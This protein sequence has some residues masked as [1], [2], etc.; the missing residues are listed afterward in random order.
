[1]AAEPPSPPPSAASFEESCSLFDDSTTSYTPFS[2][3]EKAISSTTTTDSKSAEDGSFRL[4]IKWNKR[5]KFCTIELDHQNANSNSSKLKLHQLKAIACSKLLTP[6]EIKRIKD[7]NGEVKLSLVRNVEN[8]QLVELKNDGDVQMLRANDTVEVTAGNVKS[9][10]SKGIS[11]SVVRWF[12][13]DDDGKWKAYTS[14]ISTQMETAL[15]AGK[16]A[17]TIL[18]G[19][20]CI[21]FSSREQLR[22][23]TQKTRRCLR[24][25]W[26]WTAD[27]GALVPYEEA[28]ATKLEAAYTELQSDT[29][30]SATKKVAVDTER[31]CVVNKDESATQFN[32][33]SSNARKVQRGYS[34]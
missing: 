21:R 31:Y 9:G 15:V 25:T 29:N 23:S 17:V 33:S 24:G 30:K 3:D 20:Y 19:L 11:S 8:Q 28:V 32:N 14:D 13:F 18:N 12:W 27:S 2:V 4:C 5:K 16:S 22:P 1:M 10:D 26:F 6:Q 34:E 7:I